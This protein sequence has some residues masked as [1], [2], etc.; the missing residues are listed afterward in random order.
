[1][2]LPETHRQKKMDCYGIL[3]HM[4]SRRVVMAVS[5][6]TTYKLCTDRPSCDDDR[7]GVT[8][9]SILHDLPWRVLATSVTQHGDSSSVITVEWMQSDVAGVVS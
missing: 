2:F 5:C 8:F 3:V 1:M 7:F 9:P 6:E 4:T